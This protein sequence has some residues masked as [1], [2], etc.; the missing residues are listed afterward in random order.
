MIRSRTPIRCRFYVVE[1]PVKMKELRE[2]E[3][4]GY[5]PFQYWPSG[6]SVTAAVVDF[7]IRRW[8]L[9]SIAKDKL[10]E[11]GIEVP[12]KVEKLR[13]DYEQWLEGWGYLCMQDMPADC[14]R[15]INEHFW[16]LG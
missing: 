15:V 10:L 13:I 8:K 7:K 11:K 6:D 16:E 3:R 9:Y 14:Q 12:E 2:Y 5:R 4:N 1:N